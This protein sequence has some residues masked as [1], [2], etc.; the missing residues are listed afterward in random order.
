MGNGNGNKGNAGIRG[1]W[2]ECDES[3][4][5]CGKSLWKCGDGNVGNRI[6]IGKTK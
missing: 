3:G 1:M 5:E 6:E 2:W 4:W